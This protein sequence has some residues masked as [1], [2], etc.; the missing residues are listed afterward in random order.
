MTD[1][2]LEFTVELT[3]IPKIDIDLVLLFQEQI[4]RTMVLSLDA[5]IMSVVEKEVEL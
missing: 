2:M 1:E 5:E 3:R 4:T